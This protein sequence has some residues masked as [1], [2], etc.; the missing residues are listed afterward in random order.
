M[1]G[2]TAWLTGLPSAGKTSIAEHAAAE[3]AGRYRV[4]VL[5]GDR[6]RKTLC[7]DLGFSRADRI[8]NVA[9]IGH[10]AQ[11]LARNGV[12]VLVAV[13]APYRHSR[14][15]VRAHHNGN[16]TPFL[17]VYVD[18]PVELCAKR[19]L[20]GLY[21]KQRAG[22]ISGLTGVDDPYEAPRRPDAVL[23]TAR[24]TVD[25]SARELVALVETRMAP[26]G[27]VA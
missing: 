14:D 9:R 5:D 18:T 15:E 4:Q 7:A 11:L 17:E 12:V 16:D 25:E 6:L 26:G 3:L 2:L 21:A 22:M 23:S 27:G 20:K 24:R 19:D 13:I 1:T 10:V 8:A